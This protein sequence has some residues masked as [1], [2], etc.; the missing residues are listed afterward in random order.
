MGGI[1]AVI[2]KARLCEIRYRR[3]AVTR[4][5]LLM[6]TLSLRDMD[7]ERASKF[8]VRLC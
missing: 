2:E 1:S 6:F 5:A 7:I 4:D 8:A 3:L